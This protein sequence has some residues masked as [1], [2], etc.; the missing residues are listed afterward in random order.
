M[1]LLLL[2]HADFDLKHHGTINLVLDRRHDAE[3]GADAFTLD[4][5]HRE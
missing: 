4:G 2:P 1:P 3:I 5:E